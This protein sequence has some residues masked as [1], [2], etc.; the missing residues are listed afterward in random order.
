MVERLTVHQ[1]SDLILWLPSHLGK[2]WSEDLV[3][4][5]AVS[6]CTHLFKRCGIEHFIQ[7]PML[8]DFGS[9]FAL[10]IGPDCS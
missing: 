1:H 2:L 7:Y 4:I 10:L 8:A 3:L 5:L 6:C 9:T